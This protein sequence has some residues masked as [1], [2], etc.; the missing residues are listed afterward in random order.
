MA[1][2]GKIQNSTLSVMFCLDVSG[3]RA[4]NL[5]DKLN[6]I[7]RA[8]IEAIELSAKFRGAGDYCFLRF[9]DELVCP[10]D[11]YPAEDLRQ[12]PTDLYDRIT[13]QN[14]IR[15]PTFAPSMATSSDVLRA[16]DVA[17]SRL[18]QRLEDNNRFGFQVYQPAFLIVV[19]A[20]DTY[21]D[22]SDDTI[23]DL[24]DKLKK[25]GIWAKDKETAFVA[26]I[27]IDISKGGHGI[28][29]KRLADA[30]TINGKNTYLR[31]SPNCGIIQ[32]K[33]QMQKLFY[34]MVSSISTSAST[35]KTA[36]RKIVDAIN[37]FRM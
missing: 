19:S 14:R 32:F 8:V 7:V 4:G 20:G 23:L 29:L 6:A 31:I 24:V 11:F 27:F 36:S 13:N 3:M 12:L 21:T 16:V 2:Y 25:N 34:D 18:I 1:E 37:G 9:D 5:I 15:C 33:D 17:Y 35:R 22:Q 26:P 30:F 28:C 10:G